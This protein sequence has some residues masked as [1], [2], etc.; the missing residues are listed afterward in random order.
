MSKL[1]AL[2]ML[3]SWVLLFGGCNEESSSKGRKGQPGKQKTAWK[4]YDK[5]KQIIIV[6][7]SSSYRGGVLI[8]NSWGEGICLIDGHEQSRSSQYTECRKTGMW[9]SGDPVG[10]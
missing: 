6:Q 9:A 3:E 1:P 10:R 5:E 8:V 7:E 4:E 2:G